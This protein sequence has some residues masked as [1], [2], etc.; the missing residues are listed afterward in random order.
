MP[1]N[2]RHSSGSP[3][4]DPHSNCET[5]MNATDCS[6]LHQWENELSHEAP[7]KRWPVPTRSSNF[8][9][10]GTPS[11]WICPLRVSVLGFQREAAIHLGCPPQNKTHWR[12]CL[13]RG[14][15]RRRASALRRDP[16][17]RLGLGTHNSQ[18]GRRSEG[19]SERG[20]FRAFVG[21]N[22]ISCCL[23]VCW[24]GLVSLFCC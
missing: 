11:K 16:Q 17:P 9:F 13:A 12:G 15:A 8:S 10:P 18:L 2:S 20:R 14:F 6:E 1:R 19:S 4:R 7:M 22:Y 3:K 23:V 21:G 5:P 24:F